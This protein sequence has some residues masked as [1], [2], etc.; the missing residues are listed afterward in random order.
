MHALACIPCDVQQ[1]C[2]TTL[3]QRVK[4]V[5]CGSCGVDYLASIAAFPKPDQKL[6]TDAL[7]VCRP[8][9][10]AQQLA[11]SCSAAV[12]WVVKLLRGSTA[13]QQQ[14]ISAAAMQCTRTHLQLRFNC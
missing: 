7:E 14:C 8:E 11:S 5:G 12:V 10:V 13:S 9:Q 4:V 6:R 2:Q 1:G 3:D